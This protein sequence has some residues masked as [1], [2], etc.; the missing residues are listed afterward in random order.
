MVGAEEY[1]SDVQYRSAGR[2]HTKLM[3][4]GQRVVFCKLKLVV[5]GWRH[6]LIKSSRSGSSLRS[7]L[8]Q[9]QQGGNVLMLVPPHIR[10]MSMRVGPPDCCS[11]AWSICRTST[12][13]AQDQNHDR[14]SSRNQSVNRTQVSRRWRWPAMPRTC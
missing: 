14:S 1:M 4:K 12:D 11:T 5:A 3:Y 13:R 8:K 6:H 10:T 7:L 2:G 9:V